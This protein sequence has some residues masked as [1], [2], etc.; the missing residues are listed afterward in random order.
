MKR[1]SVMSLAMAACLFVIGAPVVA[2]HGTNA[3]YDMGKHVTLTGV[4]TEFTWSNPHC[5]IYFDVKDDNGNVVHW[6]AEASSPGQL[7][8][9]G[10]TKDLLKAGDQITITLSPSRAS[11]P[12]G[13]LEKIVL[14]SGK[15]MARGAQAGQ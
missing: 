1:V 13:V 2:H 3:S 9:S 8:I 7:R 14:P 11:T 12:V 6:A 15:V 5:Q 10:W 4:V